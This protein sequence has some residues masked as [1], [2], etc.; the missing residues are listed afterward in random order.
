MSEHQKNTGQAPVYQIRIEGHLGE[1]WVDVF[2]GM[3]IS[4]MDDGNTVLSGS[5]VDQAA[6]HSLLRRIRDVGM[7][8]IS[9]VRLDAPTQA[10]VARSSAQEDDEDEQNRD[11]TS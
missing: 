3:D 11:S 9:V 7:T 5:V 2:D 1:N 8:L 10:K 6:L 4:L